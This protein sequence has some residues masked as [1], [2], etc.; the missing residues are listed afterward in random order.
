MP[1][2]TKRSMINSYNSFINFLS[3]IV[4][5]HLQSFLNATEGD[6]LYF[7][8]SGILG[9]EYI[10]AKKTLERNTTTFCLFYDQIWL[11]ISSN[12]LHP[13]WSPPS[14]SFPFRDQLALPNSSITI[15]IL[16]CA[17]K[18][19]I[20]SLFLGKKLHIYKCTVKGSTPSLVNLGL[21]KSV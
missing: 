18:N 14:A 8:R 10:I 19:W 15:N 16:K 13:Q 6:W 17:C 20:H 1:S 12:V 5:S 4:L 7:S 3:R 11:D 2:L 9:S 21:M